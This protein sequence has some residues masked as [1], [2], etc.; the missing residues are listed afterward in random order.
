VEP[1]D[2]TAPRPWTFAGIGVFR[3]ELFKD[4]PTG[5]FPLLPAL[6]RAMDQQRLYGQTFGGTWCNVGTPAQLDA[7]QHFGPG[8]TGSDKIPPAP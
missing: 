3:H 6:R 4:C 8:A 7:L 2:P 5:K 1:P